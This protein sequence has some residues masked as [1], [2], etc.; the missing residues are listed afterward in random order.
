M[1]DQTDTTQVEQA[2][3]SDVVEPANVDVPQTAPEAPAE[4]TETAAPTSA[5]SPAAESIELPGVAA[6]ANAL[7]GDDAQPEP[8]EVEVHVDTDPVKAQV[9]APETK[10]VDEV[11]VHETVVI[12]DE[13]ITDPS[14]PLAVQIPDAG[15]GT[16]DLPIHALSNPTPEAFFDSKR[17]SDES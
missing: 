5:D 15:R 4:S 8:R 9:A 12:M 7:V 1:S 6:A 3:Q 13:V 16:L 17:D 11:Y 14:S 10:P 2:P